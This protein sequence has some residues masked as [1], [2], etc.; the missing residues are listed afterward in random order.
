MIKHTLRFLYKYRQYTLINIFGLATAITACWFI[1][2]YVLMTYQYDGFHKKSDRIYRLTMKVNDEHYATTGTPLGQVIY[3]EYANIEAYAKMSAMEGIIKIDNQPFKEDG[4]YSVNAEVLDLFSFDFIIGDPSN[5]FSNPMS[6]V[7]SRTLAEKYFDDIQVI[8]KTI[9]IGTSQYLVQGVFEDW[10]VNTHL[11]VNA[12]VYKGPPMHEYSLQSYFDLNQYNY[13]LTDQSSSMTELN[14]ILENFHSNRIAP[15]LKNSGIEVALNAQPIAEIYLAPALIDD[16][17]KGNIKYLLAIAFAG[18]LVLLI[19]VFNFLNLSLTLSVKRIKEISVKRMVGMNRYHLVKAAGIE[20]LLITTI[21]LF[22]SGLLTLLLSNAYRSFTGLKLTYLSSGG[23]IFIITFL[24]V[25]TIGISSNLYF[26][27]RPKFSK[28]FAVKENAFID[29]F[30]KALI[31]FQFMI[32]LV[33]IIVTVTIIKQ[34]NFL[35]NKELGFDKAQIMIISLPEYEEQKDNYVRY[36]QILEDYG[37]IQ[38]TSLVGGGALPG[39][40]NQKEIFEVSDNG[41]QVQRIFNLYRIDENYFDLLNIQFSAGRNFGAGHF[42]DTSRSVIVN[43]KLADALNWKNPLGK[44]IGYGDVKMEVIGVVK[45]FHNKS[46]HNLIEPIVFINDINYSST[47]LVKANSSELG[48]V[49]TIWKDQIPNI[50]VSISYFDQFIDGQYAKE[51]DIFILTI[52]FAI[53]IIILSCL[54][55]FAVFSFYSTLRTKEVGIRKVNGAGIIN[56]A[57][58]LNKSI[59]SWI[60]ASFII[61]GPL[62][63]YA[64]NKWLEDFAYKTTLDWWIFVLAGLIALIIALLT[65]SYHTIKAARANPVEALKYE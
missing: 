56:I 22:I 16:V 37:S 58:I 26:G 27:I 59:L 3:E 48:L 39:E 34:V 23:I 6:I 31:S 18:I 62:A 13:I 52:F 42:T 10:P 44:N 64:M 12:L 2:N 8:N 14:N 1:F 9:S 32:S 35:K 15:G 19:A 47:L 49:K 38:N 7:L 28:F 36:K 43:E 17:P 57:L 33:V 65:V 21:V 55:L 51:N 46:L 25:F 54:G 5:C 53:V 45:D 41:Q 11:A 40:N 20:S 24:I 29:L 60:V 4:I 63:W 30:K 50:P 61:A